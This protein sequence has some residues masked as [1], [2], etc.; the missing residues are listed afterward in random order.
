MLLSLLS[1]KTRIL[2]S[3]FPAFALLSFACLSI[4]LNSQAKVTS[5]CGQSD[6]S[7]ESL[8]QSF[9]AALVASQLKV[10]QTLHWSHFMSKS[11]NYRLTR[12]VTESPFQASRFL[13]IS[14]AHGRQDVGVS[15]P[16]LRHQAHRHKNMCHTSN[17]RLSEL[18]I[19]SPPL[20]TIISSAP[21]CINSL[22][23]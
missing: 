16:G 12:I 1:L 21:D 2:V 20:K 19:L 7:R 22:R 15:C 13:R 23:R 3:P 6:I 18:V 8:S 4:S 14:R 11:R 10:R 9:L 17:G 5:P